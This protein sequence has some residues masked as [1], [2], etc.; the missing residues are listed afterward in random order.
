MYELIQEQIQHIKKQSPLVVNIT[1][2]VTMNV[3]ANGLLSLGASPIMT[4]AIE[5]IQDL[6]NIA[7]AIVINMGTLNAPFIDLCHQ[8]CVTANQ[9]NKPIIFD[10]VGAG[11]SMYRT[12]TCLDLLERYQ[13]A[14][15]RGN[16]SEI[17][18][19]AGTGQQTKGV[20]SSSTTAYAIDS[21]Q[22]L[23]TKHQLL[24]AVSGK[25]DA[26]VNRHQTQYFDRGHPMMPKMTGSGCLL[27]ALIGA[28]IA[29][30]HHP[31]EAVSAAM[32]FY[33][34]CGE[35]AAGKSNGPGTF[36]THFLDVLSYLPER[37]DYDSF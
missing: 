33:G 4:L 30:H 32:L 21:A 14:V 35:I 28:F 3:V 17:M 9:C 1:N 15:I 8:V 16:A 31:Q 29:V 6:M 12:K 18:A 36:A 27:T 26:V 13:F 11:A 7:D 24:V 37:K 23:V 19:L 22:N 20:D 5:E 10:P 34:V 2:H 25:T